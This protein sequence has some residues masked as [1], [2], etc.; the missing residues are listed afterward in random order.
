MKFCLNRAGVE[1]VLGNKHR[2]VPTL[3]VHRSR[4]SKGLDRK[5]TISHSHFHMNISIMLHQLDLSGLC[6]EE[7]IAMGLLRT[8]FLQQMDPCRQVGCLEGVCGL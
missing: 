6:L 5:I 1:N 2:Y 8:S 4:S 7:N 3:Y